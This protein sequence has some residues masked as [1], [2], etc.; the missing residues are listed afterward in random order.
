MRNGSVSSDH[1]LVTRDKGRFLSQCDKSKR[2]GAF[3]KHQK[4]QC[5]KGKKLSVGKL[6]RIWGIE[7]NPSKV[8]MVYSEE[9][10]CLSDLELSLPSDFR[11]RPKHHRRLLFM[12]EMALEVKFV[13]SWN[14]CVTVTWKKCVRLLMGI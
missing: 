8:L 12:I 7:D 10:H 13:V 9:K 1:G 6:R 14:Y 4:K 5:H 3:E 11:M 2:Q